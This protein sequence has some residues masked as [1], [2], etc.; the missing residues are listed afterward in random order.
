MRLL[1]AI[2]AGT[3]VI[4]A[5]TGCGATDRARVDVRLDAV[6]SRLPSNWHASVEETRMLGNSSTGGT[7][8]VA[9][10]RSGS[11]RVFALSGR[12]LYSLGVIIEPRDHSRLSG[13]ARMIRVHRN[14]RFTATIHVRRRGTCA[15]DLVRG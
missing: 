8:V 12:G 5:A 14:G 9:L 4:L 11:F 15:I 1:T 10:R 2:C 7:R 6:Q 13:C 3:I